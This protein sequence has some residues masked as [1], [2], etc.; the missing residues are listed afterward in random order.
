MIIKFIKKFIT[1]YRINLNN[2]SNYLGIFLILITVIFIVFFGE[3]F[4]PDWIPY[5]KFYYKAAVYIKDLNFSLMGSAI[6]ATSFSKFINYE[7]FRLI[8]IVFYIFAYIKI[9]KALNYKLKNIN[10]VLALPL[11]AFLI[12]KV[13]VQIREAFAILIWFYAVLDKNKNIISIKKITL[14]F[15]SMMFHAGTI[16]LWTPFYILQIKNKYIINYKKF[17]LPLFFCFIALLSCSTYLRFIVTNKMSYFWNPGSY[18]PEDFT[19]FKFLFNY[20]IKNLSLEKTTY[21]IF[22]FVLIIIIYIEELKLKSLALKSTFKNKIQHLLGEISL[23]GLFYYSFTVFILIPL[24]EI[25][26]LDYNIIFRVSSLLIFLL[27]IYRS[28]VFPKRFLTIIL[29]LFFSIDIL[30]IIFV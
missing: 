11:V 22:Y 30:R 27:T 20:R 1:K 15:F 16:I 29:N 21:W 6:I 24:T 18:F 14:T 26:A 7:L 17:I 23:N 19:F 28:L 8:L 13:H 3:Y 4:N 9:I 12:L 2:I 25:N 10:I 5:R